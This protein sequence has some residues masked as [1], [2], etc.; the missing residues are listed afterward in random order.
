MKTTLF[1]G[2]I[3]IYLG[4]CIEEELVQNVTYVLAWSAGTMRNYQIVNDRIEVSKS[5][6]QPAETGLNVTLCSFN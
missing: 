4:L 5:T 1:L 2:L 3:Q 6:H